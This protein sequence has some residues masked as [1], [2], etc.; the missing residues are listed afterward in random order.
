MA[1]LF[2]GK[3]I[4]KTAGSAADKGMLP[5]AALLAK[6]AMDPKK[7]KKLPV[8]STILNEGAGVAQMTNTLS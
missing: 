6:E 1:S 5:G 8:A 2:L 4:V 7:K 3:Q